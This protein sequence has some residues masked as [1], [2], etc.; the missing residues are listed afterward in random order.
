MQFSF[1]Q[2]GIT[3]QSF[4]DPTCLGNSVTLNAIV[5]STDYG[6]DSYTFQVIP[7]APLDTTTGTVVDPT[8]THC[9][10]LSGGKDDCWGGPYPIGFNFCFFSQL[11]TEFYV[12]SNGWIG[13]RNPGTNPWNTYVAR[14]IPNNAADS[15]A[16]KDCIFAPW[17]DWLPTLSGIN[18]IFYYTTGTLPDR[19]LVV[20]WKKCPMFGCTTTKG[21]FQIVL[22]EQGGVIENH[23]QLK[24]SCATSGNKATQGVHNNNGTIAF[25][26]TV[27]SINRNNTSWTATQESMRFVPNGVSWHTGSATGPVVGYSDT[28]T[29]SPTVTTWVYAVINTCLGVV[30]YDSALVHVV[31]TLTGPTPVC[32]GIPATYVTEAGMTD[33]TWSI[34]AGG[35]PTGGGTA[36]DNTVTVTWNTPGAQTVGIIFTDPVTGCTSTVKRIL[37]VTVKDAP[38]PVIT[39]PQNL[40]LNTPGH[41]YSTQAGKLNY[42]WNVTGGSVSAGGGT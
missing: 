32:K 19:E 31:P 2:S 40:C 5:T 28:I 11:Y 33:Y 25:T 8:L 27:N 21:S 1:A 12:G 24:P 26:A 22:K 9:G 36:T 6:T 16:P 29:F 42:T 4:P 37:N 34:S 13:F 23:L 14:V 7:Y 17:Q 10:A 30:H 38:V 15:A 18:N 39:G 41:V 35:L 3:I 20:Y